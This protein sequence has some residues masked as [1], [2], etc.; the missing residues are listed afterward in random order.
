M[1]Y[2]QHYSQYFAAVS[3]LTLP[4]TVRGTVVAAAVASAVASTLPLPTEAVQSPEAHFNAMQALKAR[5][6]IGAFNDVAVLNYEQACSLVRKFW[7]LR[8]NAAHGR[9]IP[10]YAD[11]FFAESLFGLK[12]LLS[13]DELSILNENTVAFG[14][15]RQ[16]AL[17]T[18]RTLAEVALG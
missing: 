1:L 16:T 3:G 17:G 6:T 13:D 9:T 11:S 7:L 10:V 2:N 15:V 18:L 14:K 4:S 8:Y 12:Y 5:E